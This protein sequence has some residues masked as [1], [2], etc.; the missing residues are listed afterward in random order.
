MRLIA[1]LRDPV[2]RTLSQYFHAC[3]NGYEQLDLISALAAEEKRMSGAHEV[4]SAADGFHYSYQKH[5][6]ISR[7]RYEIQL[8]RYRECFPKQRL[9]V[10]RVKIS[11]HTPTLGM[12]C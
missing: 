8:K 10:L 5:S 2:E 9:L 11:L 1:L 3:R 12:A 7:S 6:Y 4:V